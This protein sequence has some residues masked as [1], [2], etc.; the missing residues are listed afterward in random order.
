[1]KR[2]FTLIMF[3]LIVFDLFSQ[4]KP[5]ISFEDLLQS[6]E[7]NPSL[8][9]EAIKVTERLNIPHTIYLPQGV[10]CEAL[11]VENGVPVYAVIKNLLNPYLNGETVFFEELQLKYDLSKARLHYADGRITNPLLGYQV[12]TSNSP[13]LLTQFILLMES[14]NKRV[15]TLNKINGN[16]INLNY[17][18]AQDTSKLSTPKQARLGSM[19]KITI[20]DQIKDVV[21]MY[22]TNGTHIQI[23]APAG[24]VNNTLLDNIRGHNYKHNG[25]LLVTVGSGGNQDAIAEFTNTG[26][27]VG[28]FIAAGLGGLSSPFDVLVRTADVIVTGYSS[29]QLHRYS[30]T[31]QHIANYSSGSTTSSL[32]QIIQL[33]NGKL[34]VADFGVGGGVRIYDTSYT[35]VSVLNKLTAL[36]GVCELENGNLLI[37][38]AAGCFELNPNTNDTVRSIITGVSGQYVTPYDPV[39][40]P[41]ELI[42]FNTSLV[43]NV[44]SVT[45]TTATEK[46]NLGFEIER[47][48]DLVNYSSLAFINGKGTS[49]EHNYYSFIDRNPLQGKSYYRLKQIDFDGTISY[50]ETSEINV[51]PVNFELQQNYPNPFNPATTINYQIPVDGYVTLKIFNAMGEE[52]ITLV[53]EKQEAGNY[54]VNFNSKDLPSGIYF[55]KIISGNFTQVKKMILAK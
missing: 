25:N 8:K 38:N 49:V 22:D 36:R 10:F 18:P 47:S 50:S 28:Q 42:S 17:V 40:V 11:K 44:V 23:L 32:Q 39:V 21:Q 13:K 48:K 46:N 7:L 5:Q 37:T 31:G 41:V 4:V 29:R 51:L 14:T 45:W 43:S 54:S 2:I 26:T 12:Q 55:Y 52:V 30:L 24:G 9:L 53:N 20:S 3:T 35:V 1:M 6:S 16:I 34:A 27:Y 15:I 33:S 19:G